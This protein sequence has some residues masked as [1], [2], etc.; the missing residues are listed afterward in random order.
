MNP[1]ISLALKEY[2]EQPV[3]YLRIESIRV[4]R[5]EYRGITLQGSEAVSHLLEL[6]QTTFDKTRRYRVRS[7]G[8]RYPEP[9]PMGTPAR[10]LSVEIADYLG[11]MR[12]RN[13]KPGT[14]EKAARTLHIL[15]MATGDVPVS[16]ILHK[17]IYKLW[18]LLIWSP[19][20]LTSDPALVGLPVEQLIALGKTT[21]V[22]PPA[23]ATLELHRRF[24]TSFFNQLAKARAIPFSP[25]DAFSEMKK[26]LIE[27]PDKPVRLFYAADLKRIFQPEHFVPWASQSPHRWWAPILGLYTGA[28][29]NEICQLKVDDVIQENGRWFLA[30]RKTSQTQSLK[31][32]SAVRRIPIPQPV[33][34][35]GFLDFIDDIK[36]FGHPRLFPHLS[37]GTNSRS[38]HSNAR[39]S[40]GFLIQ[41]GRYL[42]DLGFPKGIRFHA[43]RHTLATALDNSGVR[44]ED[45][46]LITG[47]SV[48]KKVP[49]LDEHYIHKAPEAIRIRQLHAIDQYQPDLV[50]PQYTRGQFRKRLRK[51]VKTYP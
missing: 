16:R 43:F 37:A 7:D 9:L 38:G 50:L 22:A 6:I 5:V 13:L 42:K 47:H 49:V 35:A 3:G 31:G 39:Y 45:I 29:V 28:R 2:A 36:A 46:A 8:M 25:M 40:Q 17:E 14:I 19:P 10:K 12:R 51:D 11:D 32:R 48:S 21:Y 30:I 4:G 1:S 20:N 24:L 34:D 33:I 27:D 23:V 44:V 26:D 15:R 18:D 41:F